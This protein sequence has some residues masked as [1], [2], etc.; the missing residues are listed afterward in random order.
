MKVGNERSVITYL[1][2]CIL[3][4]LGAKS[5]I[6][7][8]LGTDPLDVL[9][10]GIVKHTGLTIGIVSGLIAVA[11]LVIWSIWNR[12]RPL[13]TPFLT[14]FFVGN[15]IDLWNY[16]KI[17]DNFQSTAF[18]LLLIGLLLASIGSSLILMSGI[19]IRTIDLVAITMVQKW[20]IKFLYAKLSIEI[21][22]VVSGSLLGG[23]V[24]IGTLAFLLAVSPG[25]VFFVYLFERM[26]GTECYGL[27]PS[28]EPISDS[29]SNK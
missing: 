12:R 24:G 4:S 10:L 27:H 1:I 7:S 6:D 26:F 11:F 5:F 23:P 3:F 13:V 22:M 19:G 14:M 21:F 25:I 29:M 28:V 17:E 8:Q 16:L 9:V 15:L 18:V 20:R 2:G